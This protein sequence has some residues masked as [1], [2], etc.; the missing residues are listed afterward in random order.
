MD[1]KKKIK[2][3]IADDSSVFR[4]VLRR[5]LSNDSGLEVVAVA[6]N[7]FEARDR[8]VEFRPDVM[9]L[10]V[11]MPRMNGIDFLKKLMPQ[12]PLP[13][14]VISSVTDR[15]F[16]AL[17]AGAVDF[18]GKPKSSQNVEAFA[19]EVIVKIKIASTA[20]IGYHKRA[21][22][23]GI[24][25]DDF[26][27][28]KRKIIAIGAST[29]GTKAIQTVLQSFPANMPGTVI[30]QHMPPVFTKLYSE[31][32][33]NLCRVEVKEAE[34]GDE[35]IPGKVLIAP[36]GYHLRAVQRK[37]SYR[38]EMEEQND[39]NK[40]NVHCPSVDVMF[41]SLAKVAGNRT[42]GVILTGM[43]ND[44]AAGLLSLR[45]S[46][47][48]T[49]GQDE[50]SCVVYGMPKVAYELGAVERQESLDNI[51]GTI[52]SLLKETKGRE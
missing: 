30:V 36:G 27:K 31:R 4:E 2:V 21:E 12:Y 8:I 20:K 11:E 24:N 39:S 14:V 37:G 9:T 44:G 45:K 41:E 51:Y 50:K 29:G 52:A 15:V 35:I 19:K 32:L 17:A 25:H 16:D 28:A 23:F 22:K 18:V 43:G 5:N 40:V 49:V 26:E 42:I 7:P 34:D 33:N 10:D 48:R 3:L 1:R 6:S 38:I 13:T 47:A 46:G